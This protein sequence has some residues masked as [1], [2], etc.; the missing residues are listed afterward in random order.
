MDMDFDFA[1]LLGHIMHGTTL[2]YY[3]GYCI[4]KSIVSLNNAKDCRA[5]F[6]VL[7]MS[8]YRIIVICRSLYYCILFDYV[9]IPTLG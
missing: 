8:E 3:S 7:Y 2:S 5:S 6:R 4:T 1:Y 9:F